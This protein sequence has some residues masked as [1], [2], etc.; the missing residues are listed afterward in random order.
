MA[1]YDLTRRISNYL[2]KHL[3]LPLLEY[4]S[5]KNVR[6]MYFI[7]ASQVY[8]EDSLLKSKLDV[9]MRTSMLDYAADTYQTLYNND[10]P[11]DFSG[12]RAAVLDRIQSFEVKLEPVKMIFSPETMKEVAQCKNAKDLLSSLETKYNFKTEMLDDLFDA[13]RL[14]YDI[15]N[16]NT[17]S[18][19]LRIVRQLVT[20]GSKRHLEACWGRLASEILVQNWNEAM[21]DLEKLKEAVDCQGDDRASP[22]TCLMQLQ[23]RTWMLHWSLFVF[24]NH[25]QGKEKLIEWFMQNPTHLNAIQS[26]A[27]HLLRY[28]TVC[29]ITNTDKKK[30]S[31]IRDLVYL[32]QQESYSYRD[33]VTEFLECLF[34]KFDFDG[35]QQRLRTCETVLPND[36]FLTGCYEE[37]IENAR[38]LMF[39]SFCR[40]HHSVGIS[41]LA[42]KL[43][44]DVDSAEKWIVKL[45][46]DTRIDAKIDSQKGLIVMG[47]QKVSPYQQVIERTKTSGTCAHKLLERLR[48]EKALDSEWVLSGTIT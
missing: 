11:E 23:Q 36:F 45:I 18:E 25:P 8:D 17:A 40:I 28:L 31:L 41:M 39:E 9:L 37:F 47:T 1:E 10:V 42:D 20:P 44:M 16:Y 35:T 7:K 34:V 14:F 13:A 38:L 26:L 21:D 4:I 32:I 24:F 29:V 43:N 15:G 46:R 48:W 22:Q 3:I 27:P 30:K 6:V 12:K 5:V 2:D 33:P 19:Y